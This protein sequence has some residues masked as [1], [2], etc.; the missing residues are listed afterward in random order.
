MCIGSLKKLQN[1]TKCHCPLYP[2]LPY[3]IAAALTKSRS[4]CADKCQNAIPRDDNEHGLFDT[5][6]RPNRILALIT[7]QV[8][9]DSDEAPKITTNRKFFL[10][11]GRWNCVYDLAGF[12]GE[13]CQIATRYN[14]QRGNCQASM[15][16]IGFI[17]M[18]PAIDGIPS[19]S[20]EAALAAGEQTRNVSGCGR[21]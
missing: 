14:W 17:F 20:N 21:A 10:V 3:S 4:I 15:N 12:K 5:F 19:T 6:V 11:F 7:S 2:S 18:L 8:S 16:D 13:R 1:C 9:V